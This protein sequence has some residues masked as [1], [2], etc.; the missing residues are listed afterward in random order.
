MEFTYSSLG[1]ICALRT[2]FLFVLVSVLACCDSGRTRKRIELELDAGTAIDD[3]GDDASAVPPDLSFDG[4]DGHALLDANLPEDADAAAAPEDADAAAS[5]DDAALPDDAAS[6][7]TDAGL[8]CRSGERECMSSCVPCPGAPVSETTCFERACVAAACEPRY[9]VGGGGECVLI[10]ELTSWS[11]VEALSDTAPTTT[12]SASG[13]IGA[14]RVMSYVDSSG[15]VHRLSLAGL[16]GWTDVVLSTD[17]P[18]LASALVATNAGEHL[19]YLTVAGAVRYSDL[20]AASSAEVEVVAPTMSARSV[21]ASSVAGG[22]LFATYLTADFHLRTLHFSGVSVDDIAVDVPDDVVGASIATN[23]SLAA[24][25]LVYTTRSGGFYVRLWNGV[26]WTDATALRLAPTFARSVAATL[27]PSA[28]LRVL[29]TSPGG[30][31]RMALYASGS[32]TYRA[33]T[34]DDSLVDDVSLSSLGDGSM[35][36]VLRTRDNRI[37]T[38]AV[39]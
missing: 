3:M 11:P 19:L 1:S 10:D 25:H 8:S 5:P 14:P 7:V 21:S 32:W 23:P 2:L 36:A 22:A 24:A 20:S 4:A 28:G 18:A 16:S 38:N 33:I 37:L 27:T 34:V 17:A 13:T 15:N 29:L 12:V 6:G 9:D 39:Y 26:A 35:Y 30:G 31:L